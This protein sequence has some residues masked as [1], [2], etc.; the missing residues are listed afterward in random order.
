M[1]PDDSG[2]VDPF[3]STIPPPAL[4]G[5]PPATRLVPIPSTFDLAA[6]ELDE[7]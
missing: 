7:Q 2:P 5:E 3:A 4:E 6:E 1:G